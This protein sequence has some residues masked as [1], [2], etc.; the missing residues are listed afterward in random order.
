MAKKCSSTTCQ[1]IPEHA[2][3]CS[4]SKSFFCPEHLH[5]HISSP[6]NHQIIDILEGINED[7]KLNLLYMIRQKLLQFKQAKKKLAETISKLFEIIN[8]HASSVSAY[9]DENENNLYRMEKSILRLNK[10]DSQDRDCIEKTPIIIPDKVSFLNFEK[11]VSNIFE[12]NFSI[13]VEPDASE[14]IIFSFCD[15]IYNFDLRTKQKVLLCANDKVDVNWRGICMLPN[16]EFFIN[17]YEKCHIYYFKSEKCKSVK[18]LKYSGKYSSNELDGWRVPIYYEDFVY[19]MGGAAY[20][21]EKFKIEGRVWE[22]I[23]PSPL[24]SNNTIFG[25]VINDVIC[26]GGTSDQYIYSFNTI[27]QKYKKCIYLGPTHTAQFMG[28]GYIFTQEGYFE[29]SKNNIMEVEKK[30]YSKYAKFTKSYHNIFI[31][32]GYIYSFVNCYKI[33]RFNTR[34]SC[35]DLFTY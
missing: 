29:V 11:E 4:G 2:C 21:N 9:I 16:D 26:L 5:S 10:I 23:K 12:S 6:S 7:D 15:K 20:N 1:S 27:K 31:R 13:K 3:N 32:N 8:H 33:F 25:N 22:N 24:L 18:D 28:F 30:P 17:T 35:V 14:N 19:L 34:N